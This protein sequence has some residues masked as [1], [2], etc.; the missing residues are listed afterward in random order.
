V[1][2]HTLHNAI[3]ID[4]EQDAL[5][6]AQLISGTALDQDPQPIH[7]SLAAED[8]RVLC[9]GPWGLGWIADPGRH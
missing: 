9:L 5:V 6:P 2:A 1:V 8:P 3:Q 4:A 7:E